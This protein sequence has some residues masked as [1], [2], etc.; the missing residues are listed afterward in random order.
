MLALLLLGGAT[1]ATHAAKATT[2]LVVNASPEPV[3]NVLLSLL[4]NGLV[5][6][7]AWM[8]LAHPLVALGVGLVAVAGAALLTVWLARRAIGASGRLCRD[9]ADRS[10]PAWRECLRPAAPYG[11]RRRIVDRADVGESHRIL[12]GDSPQLDAGSAAARPASRPRPGNPA[13]ATPAGSRLEGG[14]RAPASAPRRTT[15]DGAPSVAWAPART[16]TA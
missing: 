16:T 2:R 12:P 5:V 14:R 6:G 7:A 10:A 3:S 1:L 9:A 8:A 15:S 11:P 13:P 4:E